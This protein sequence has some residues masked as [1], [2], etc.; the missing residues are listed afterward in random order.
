MRT[1]R[2]HAACIRGLKFTPDGQTLISSADDGTIRFW[3]PENER[4][5]EVIQLGPSGSPLM[6]DLDSSGKYLA[7]GV[8][9]Q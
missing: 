8:P 7:A 6:F 4:S 2:G 3:N 9:A 1:L 5:W